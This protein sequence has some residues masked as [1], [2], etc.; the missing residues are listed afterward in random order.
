MKTCEGCRRTMEA[1]VE[2]VI[3]SD[4]ENSFHMKRCMDCLLVYQAKMKEMRT[5]AIYN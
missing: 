5:A 4:G 3:F 2:M 1:V